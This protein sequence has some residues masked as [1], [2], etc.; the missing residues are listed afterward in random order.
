MNPQ[1]LVVDDEPRVAG[2]LRAFLEDAGELDQ[3][4]GASKRNRQDG[5]GPSDMPL[6]PHEHYDY[7]IVLARTIHQWNRLYY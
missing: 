2:A 5:L 3:P 4:E 7:C 6:R 1:V